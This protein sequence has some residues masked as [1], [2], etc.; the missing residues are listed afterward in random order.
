M[1]KLRLIKLIVFIMTF[2]L[3]FGFLY[4]MGLIY[5]KA[6]HTQEQTT[7]NLNQPSGSKIYDYQVNNGN[8]YVL[9]KGGNISDRLIVIDAKTQNIVSSIKTN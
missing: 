6:S 8:I 3:I 5:K 4:A 7:I 2:M 1:N 9:L